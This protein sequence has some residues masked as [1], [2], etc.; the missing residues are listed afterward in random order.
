MAPFVSAP[1]RQPSLFIAGSRDGVIRILGRGVALDDLRPV[2]PGL[3]NG[4]LV[5]GAGHFIQEEAPA[6]VNALL[7]EFL[8]EPLTA[9]RGRD[10]P[11]HGVFPLL[12]GAPHRPTLGPRKSRGRQSR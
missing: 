8:R 5:E 12:R 1:I 10:R 3:T 9:D 6:A 11:A 7:L 2:L 4:V